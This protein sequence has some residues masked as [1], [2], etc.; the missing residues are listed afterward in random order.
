[1]ASEDAVEHGELSIFLRLDEKW[2]PNI[3]GDKP[4]PEPKPIGVPGAHMPSVM[5]KDHRPSYSNIPAP[6]PDKKKEVEE[7]DIST[8]LS[9]FGFQGVKMT[10]DELQQLAEELGLAKDD[11]ANL[12]EG[13]SSLNLKEPGSADKP[14]KDPDEVVDEKVVTVADKTTTEQGVLL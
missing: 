4:A 14:T 11:A 10:N 3:D 1:L 2:D 7:F 12:A 5:N 13:L 8:E 9:G 6:L